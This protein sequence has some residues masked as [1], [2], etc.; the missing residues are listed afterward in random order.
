M[1]ALL[2]CLDELD[3]LVRTQK[4][5]TEMQSDEQF[6]S[7]LHDAIHKVEALLVGRLNHDDF[8]DAGFNL[9]EAITA[10][11]NHPTLLGVSKIGDALLSY[12][13]TAIS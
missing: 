4:R 2:D 7:R 1:T 12:R 8:F 13:R 3:R 11:E 9:T 6:V 5:T 10:H